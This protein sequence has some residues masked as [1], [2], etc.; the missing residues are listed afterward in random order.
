MI[1]PLTGLTTQ[2]AAPPYVR[3]C[4]LH[5]ERETQLKIT[6]SELN[7][8]ILNQK[9]YSTSQLDRK[10]KEYWK[11]SKANSTTNFETPSVQPRIFLTGTNLFKHDNKQNNVSAIYRC[12]VRWE[13]IRAQPPLRGKLFANNLIHS[14]P[15]SPSHLQNTDIDILPFLIHNCITYED[16]PNAIDL[17]IWYN[18]KKPGKELH[19]TLINSMIQC[20]AE[21]SQIEPHYHLLKFTQLMNFL[22]EKSIEHTLSEHQAL[23]ISNKAMSLDNNPLLT[24]KV[25]SYVL[26]VAYNKSNTVRTAQVE[27]LYSLISSDYKSNNAAGVLL[28]WTAVRDHYTTI[29]KHD[30]RI[31]YKIIKLF[32][33]QKAYRQRCAELISSIEPQLYVNNAL[34]L[35]SI[36]NFASATKSYSLAT[37]IMS[38]I[39]TYSNFNT[40]KQILKSRFFLSTLLRL[41]L[42]FEDSIGVERILN[43]IRKEHN[44]LTSQDYQVIVLH[45]LKSRKPQDLLKALTLSKKIEGLKGI[46]SITTIIN[47]L[48]LLKTHDVEKLNLNVGATIHNLLLKAHNNDPTHKTKLWDILASI[49]VRSLTTYKHNTTPWWTN[50]IYD[51]TTKVDFLKLCYETSKNKTPMDITVNPFVSPNPKDTVIKLSAT[52]IIVILRTIAREANHHRRRDIFLWCMNEMTKNGM[53]EEEIELDWNNMEKHQI[54]RFKNKTKNGITKNLQEHGLKSFKTLL[55]KK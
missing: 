28:H 44:S 48:T 5:T 24:K 29:S 40:Q 43:E 17:F 7:Y 31:L 50:E 26:D 15:L 35:P 3:V 36:I 37:K 20:I 51:K 25:L 2:R 22:N 52:N 55:R 4:M 34:L 8:C 39:T 1:R 41:H 19:R 47:H 18:T 9:T 16:I 54:R 49:F 38:N 21:S 11:V 23:Q 10:I 6:T 32:T 53:T 30:T 12:F 42:T 45:L 13:I 14:S 33:K 46:P 27:A